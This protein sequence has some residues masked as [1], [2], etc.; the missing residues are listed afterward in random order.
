[1]ALLDTG[2]AI[3][4]VTQLL[5]DSLE[6]LLD[7]EYGVQIKVEAGRAEPPAQS[8]YTNRLNL[9]L[10]EASFDPS[11][12]NVP[13]QEG[14]PEP[15]WLVLHYLLTAYD[16]DGDSNS[17]KAFEYLGE[18]VRA[19]QQLNFLQV[20]NSSTLKGLKENP[21]PLK[22]TF[23]E[24]SVELLSR[25]M[26]GSEEKYRFSMAFE[27]RPVMIATMEPPASSLLVGIDYSKQPPQVLEEKEKGVHIPVIPSVAAP[28]ITGISPGKFEINETVTVK[29]NN[30]DLSGLSVRLGPVELGVTA[31]QPGKLKFEVN[32][33]LGKGDLISAGSHPLQVVKTLSYGRTRS[34]NLWIAHL[35]PTVEDAAVMGSLSLDTESMTYITGNLTLKGILLGTEK[36]DI[37]VS[38]Y[39]DGNVVSFIEGTGTPSQKVLN[40]QI[41][42]SH[43]VLPGIYRVILWVNGQQAKSSPEVSLTDTVP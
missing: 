6:D 40:I 19:L 42:A 37:I 32:G 5:C 18:G 20:T 23:N 31:Q 29:G 12:K 26:Q 13:L 24:G 34:G 38:F 8:T 14:R 10:Y 43:R 15:L 35:L 36:D 2:K 1:M 3:S 9:F 28:E 17:V 4:S 30:L 41:K 39:R 21:E 7:K 22:I 33:K 11:L 25:L 16:K 27:V